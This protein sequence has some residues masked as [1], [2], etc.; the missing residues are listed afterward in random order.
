MRWIPSRLADGWQ[1]T[2]IT[3]FQSGFPLDVV[4]SAFPSLTSSFY[5]FYSSFSTAGWDVPNQVGPVQYVNP[6]SNPSNLGPG[7]PGTNYWISP[8]AKT[9]AAPALGTEGNAAR[10]L[11][12]GPGL[13]NFDFALLKDVRIT[14]STKIELRFE[15]FNIFNHTQFDPVGITTDFN[16][17]QFGTETAAHDPRV[18]QLAGKIYF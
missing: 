18:I 2:G 1:L 7:L 11:F 13:N 8:V 14:E 15:F 5:T 10:D 16:S 4:D 9:F 3:T 12:R 6:R 17:P